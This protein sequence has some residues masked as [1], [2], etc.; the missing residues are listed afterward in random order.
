MNPQGGVT[1]KL[2]LSV[3]VAQLN[4][5]LLEIHDTRKLTYRDVIAQLV[6]LTN[7][8]TKQRNI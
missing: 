8:Q 6:A 7:T 5:H 4:W 3:G 1:T 2:C